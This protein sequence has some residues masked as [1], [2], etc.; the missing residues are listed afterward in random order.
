MN[1]FNGDPTERLARFIFPPYLGIAVFFC[2]GSPFYRVLP[3][4][5]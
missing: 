3:F 2:Y 5:G 4:A 1:D